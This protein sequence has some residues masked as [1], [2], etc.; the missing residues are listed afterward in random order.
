MYSQVSCRGSADDYSNGPELWIYQ[1]RAY[2][3]ATKTGIIVLEDE[4][5]VKWINVGFH[6]QWIYYEITLF[7]T[8]LAFD[9]RVIPYTGIKKYGDFS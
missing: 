4:L 9:N 3:L 5:L 6:S 1:C 7:N 2:T 8:M